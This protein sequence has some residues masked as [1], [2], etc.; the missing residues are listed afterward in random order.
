MSTFS[1]RNLLQ[2]FAAFFL[3]ILILHSPASAQSWG[4]YRGMTAQLDLNE[5]DIADFA[6]TGGNLLRLGF[7]RQPLM[8]KNPP[9]QF[10]ED[11]FA[12]LDQI[13]DWCR[14][15]NIKVII[16]PHT[17]PGTLR[18]TTTV[19][20]DP[21]WSDENFQ[22]LAVKQIAEIA[23]REAH[24]GDVLVGYDILNEPGVPDLNNAASSA[25]WDNLMQK[26]IAA[27]RHYDKN[28]PIIIEPPVG[29]VRPLKRLIT[30]VEG[31]EF[32][33]PP[34]DPNLI[35]SPHVY[36][37]HEFT[38]Q[39]VVN[40]IPVG[41]QYPGYINGVYWDKAKLRAALQPVLN[42]QQK[43]N[44]PIYIGEFSAARST[45]ESGVK[46]IRDL[47][48]LFEEYGWSWT[49]HAFR[50]APVW[51]AELPAETEA[52]NTGAVRQSNTARMEVL[53]QAF[54]R[55]HMAH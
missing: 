31:M 45:G 24:R 37:P 9:Y 18:N 38:H 22:D 34:S 46:Y 23:R 36:V 51:D 54:Q 39:G 3:F 49:Y 15:Y 4:P 35:Y 33:P 50:E 11:S 16:D 47:I 52:Q 8:N 44:V 13:I 26:M 48:D 40:N 43:Y 32:L 14:K 29:F 19:P 21:L 6:N 17:T 2:T 1:A 28:R 20:K 42:F 12:K 55:N 53:R 7:A 41:A 10:N 25:I 5:N 27:V 30:R